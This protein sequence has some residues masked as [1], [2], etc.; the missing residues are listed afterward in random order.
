MMDVCLLNYL[1]NSC[2]VPLFVL[3]WYLVLMWMINN[4]TKL[5]T[6]F[7]CKINVWLVLD[8]FIRETVWN[9]NTQERSTCLSLGVT[10]RCVLKLAV[11]NDAE[12]QQLLTRW[13][14]FL[15][16]SPTDFTLLGR[17]P[18]TKFFS[19]SCGFWENLIKSYPPLGGWRPPGKIL[20]PPLLIEFSSSYI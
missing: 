12:E 20:D 4:C 10:F 11:S 19:I 15:Y 8:V 13:F 2:K 1:S 7:N 18:A 6:P 5:V 14:H 3:S 17:P 9:N 16:T